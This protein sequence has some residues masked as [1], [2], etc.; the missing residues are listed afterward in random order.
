MRRRFI[1]CMAAG[2]AFSSLSGSPSLAAN[3]P[4]NADPDS[5][6]RAVG[7]GSTSGGAANNPVIPYAQPQ[8]PADAPNRPLRINGVPDLSGA[9]AHAMRLFQNPAPSGGI[10]PGVGVGPTALTTH[11]EE[12]TDR[13]G[14]RGDYSSPVLRPWAAE[15][16]KLFGDAEHASQP[17]FELCIKNRGV[18]QTW[19]LNRGM[20]LVQTPERVY[21]F[22]GQDVARIIHLN[23]KHPTDLKRSFDGDSIGYFEGDTLVVDTIGFDGRAEGDRYGTPT[24]EEMHVVERLSLKQ[25]NQVLQADFWVDDPVVYTQPWRYSLTYARAEKLGG[26]YICRESRIYG[27]GLRRGV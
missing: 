23:A 14:S 12:L 24:S 13:L 21:L 6:P 7:G 19:S 3:V 5:I 22:F 9:Y 2:A 27:K 16:V 11:P 8:A 17:Y 20:Q 4:A 26:E 15:L 18:L 25:K 1:L 10:G